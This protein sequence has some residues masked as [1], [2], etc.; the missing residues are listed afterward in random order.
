[1]G[2]SYADPGN[3]REASGQLRVPG[4]SLLG[5]EPPGPTGLEAG[6]ALHMLTLAID[7]KRVVSFAS[8]ALHCWGKS[9]RDPLNWRP[10]GRFIICTHH[11]ILLG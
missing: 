8:L 10:G 2:A 9:L 1:V 4:V 5:K 11:E 6:W 3:R 7:G